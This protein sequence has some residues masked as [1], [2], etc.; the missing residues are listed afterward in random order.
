MKRY[1][2]LYDKI[3]DIDNIRLAHKNAQRGKKHYKE[4]I[5]FNNNEEYYIQLIH[6]MLKDETFM[7]SEY[8]IFVK[9]DKGK[10]REIY[11]LPYFP[12]RVVHHA[13]MQVLEPIWFK[14]L[15]ND[16]YQSIRGRGIHKAK[17]KIEYHIRKEQPKYCL[18]LD[19]KKF[20]PS[21]NNEILKTIVRKKI[22]CDSTLSLLDGI[23]D[24]TDGVPIGNYL[25]QY[26]GNLYLTYFDHWAKEELKI[27]QYYRY[28]DD[29]VILDNSKHHLH[30][31]FRQ[32]QAKL[33]EVLS[34]TIKGNHQ[35][36]LV[37]KR[38]VDFLG[39]RF[40]F[41]YTLIRKKISKNFKK[42][43]LKV[44]HDILQKRTIQGI[45]ASY[46]G[47]TTFGD[48]TNLWSRYIDED[49]LNIWV[50]NKLSMRILRQRNK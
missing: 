35:I 49:I 21:I 42:A 3:Y 25:S 24:S 20:Y 8:E 38:G 30:R 15:I 13:I 50:S 45:V 9:N 48:G 23:I 31:V 37:N 22:K 1:G 46:N 10:T 5:D 12:D 44:K 26:L 18:Q 28:C 39:F 36:Y 16:T 34:L 4:V 11:K 6:E 27:P 47:W 29:L 41:Q 40:F 7:T 33:H 14:T 17:K 43:V 19:I 32:I 2:N